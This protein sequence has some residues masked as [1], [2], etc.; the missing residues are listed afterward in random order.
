MTWSWRLQ[1]AD[2]T[3]LD[4]DS[5][6]GAGQPAHP[7]QSDAETWLGEVWRSLAADGVA[8]AS[9]YRDDELV[10]GPMSLSE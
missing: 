8:A 1:S 5:G 9:L 2:G 10:Y 6:A 7:T 3:V 4:A